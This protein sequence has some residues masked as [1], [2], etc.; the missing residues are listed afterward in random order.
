[1]SPNIVALVLAT[2]RHPELVRLLP[3]RPATATDCGECGGKGQITVGA[4]SKIACG[5]CS[6]LGWRFTEGQD[7]DD[8]YPTFDTALD[9]FRVFAG[10]HGLPTDFVFLS[11][12]HA[13]LVEDQLF[14]TADAFSSDA[15]ARNAYEQAVGRRLGVCIGA[16]G[17]L[18]DGRLGVY[19]YGPATEHEAERL[20]YPNGLKM[21]IPERRAD[22]R[23][24][25]RLK[26]RLLRLRHGRRVAER[27][28]EY[29]R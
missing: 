20:M 19:I 27:T 8:S 17:E 11:A 25:G 6:A 9:R 5:H 16:L 28:R 24:V 23:V 15:A 21:T 4:V 26:M 7:D 14:V 1:M 3:P 18:P 29:F 12:E 22:V 13:L 10:D 2:E